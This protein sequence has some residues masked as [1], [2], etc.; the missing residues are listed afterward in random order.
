HWGYLCVFTGTELQPI[1]ISEFHGKK[2]EFPNV[3]PGLIYFPAFRKAGKM[4]TF[5]YP[6]LLKEDS[7]E[8]FIP[9]T[10]RKHCI[11]LTRK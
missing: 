4:K 7:I 9:D 3:E 2:I 5:S 10:T 1:D 11:V 8:Y 6:F